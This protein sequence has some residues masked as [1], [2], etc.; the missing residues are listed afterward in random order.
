MLYRR[1]EMDHRIRFEPDAAAL[2]GSWRRLGLQVFGGQQHWTD[3]YLAAFAQVR[4]WTVVTFD[5]N[6]ERLEGTGVDA[7]VLGR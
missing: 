2:D 6:F 4:G 7:I 3:A 5:R 1:L